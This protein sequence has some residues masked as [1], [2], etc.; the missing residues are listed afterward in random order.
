MKK[1]KGTPFS[2]SGKL[3]ALAF[4]LFA[5]TLSSS[6]AA[7]YA[8]YKVRDF[9]RIDQI[10]M[11]F[12]DSAHLQAGLR[13]EDGTIDY[14]N[15]LNEDDFRL[16]DPDYDKNIHLKEVSSMF[17]SA[18]LNS[19]ETVKTPVLRRNY[20]SSSS[21]TMTEP[22]EN[23]FV[24]IE[25][26]FRSDVACHL[27][28]DSHTVC[29]PM[30][31]FNAALASE[32]GYD[33]EELNKVLDC[34]R[35]SF[36]SEEGFYIAEPG[37]KTSSHTRFGGPLQAHN[38]QGYFDYEDDKEI[39]Y[40]EYEGTPKYL[41]ALEEDSPEPENKSAFNA[42]HK[43]GVAIVDPD[44]VD[45]AIEETH[46]LDDFL[47]QGGPT[48]GDAICLGTLSPDE[49]YRLVISVYIEGWDLD[50]T[51]TLAAGKFSLDL[52]FTGLMDI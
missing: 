2:Y 28:L 31:R 39:L 10:S 42:R 22:A 9:A 13:L 43:A 40:G 14:K 12:S 7:T 17:S 29:R 52:S 51:D 47:F 37:Q 46:P 21:K 26:F 4:G 44:S 20:A 45:Y 38:D 8:W 27:Y 32:N 48:A 35:V 23:G 50:L 5:L 49:D 33:E 3:F 19:K 16:A 41:P 6:V 30:E 24:Q 15:V 36:Y 1:A 11:G 25:A 18:W 34:V